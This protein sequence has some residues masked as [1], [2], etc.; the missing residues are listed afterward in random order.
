MLAEKI[1]NDQQQQQH[2]LYR[3]LYYY[4]QHLIISSSF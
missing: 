3:Y 4:A 1:A 2:D